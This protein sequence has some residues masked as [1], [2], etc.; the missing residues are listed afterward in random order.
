MNITQALMARAGLRWSISDLAKA[1]GVS[2]RT[3]IRFENGEPV[4]ASTVATVRQAY[5]A[6]G[7][8]FIDGGALVGALAPVGLDRS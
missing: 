6:Q 4:A 5:E 3:V 1:A 8:Q 7:V 2:S